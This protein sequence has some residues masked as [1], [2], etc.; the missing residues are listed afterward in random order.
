MGFEGRDFLPI[1]RNGKF[2]RFLPGDPCSRFGVPREQFQ[3]HAG[4]KFG[5]EQ[6]GF[7]PVGD[8]E[9]AGVTGTRAS[10]KIAV[11]NDGLLKLGMY[12]EVKFN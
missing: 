2:L 7:F 12:G 8:S 11:E 6:I 5:G 3:R 1:L 9:I 10:R 4:E